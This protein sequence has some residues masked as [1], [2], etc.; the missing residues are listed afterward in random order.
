MRISTNLFYDQMTQGLKKNLS[1]LNTLN[2]Q[3]ATEKKINKPSDDVVGTLRALDYKL[4]ISQNTQYEQNITEA[5]NYLSFYDTVL[6]QIYT[7]VG[8][9]KNL[10]RQTAATS[11]NQTLYANQAENLRDTLMSLSNSTYLNQYIFSGSLSDQPAYALNG[12]NYDYQGDTQQQTVTIGKGV[13]LTALNIPGGSGSLSQITPF[14]YFTAKDDQIVTLADGSTAKFHI[15]PTGTDL[16]HQTIQVQITD[17]NDADNNDTFTFSNVMDMANVMANAFQ[18]MDVDGTTSLASHTMAMHR[19]EALA[20]PISQIQTQA[21]T[22]Q[23]LVGVRQNQLSDQKTRLAANTLSAQ[24]SLGQTEDADLNQTIVTLQ[25]IS[26]T[27][28]AL[29]SAA[30]KILPQSLFDFLR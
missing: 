1:D 25:K 6:S 12:N 27:L 28:D 13:S 21:L 26:T 30:A 4:T 14:T 11:A 10:T 19:I 17:A 18:D 29:R 8:S 24:T 23:S 2:E 22:A 9:L 5:D 15:L 3:L 20:S 16:L 7:T